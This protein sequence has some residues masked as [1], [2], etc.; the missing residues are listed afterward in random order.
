MKAAKISVFLCS[1]ER[2]VMTKTSG[3][4]RKKSWIELTKNVTNKTFHKVKETINVVKRQ[5]MGMYL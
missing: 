3:A 4:L 1:W 5:T 2:Q